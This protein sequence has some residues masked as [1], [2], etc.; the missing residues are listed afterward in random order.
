MAVHEPRKGRVVR[1]LLGRQ[2]AKRDVLFARAL[3]HARG[4]DPTRIGVEQQRNHYRRVIGRPATPIDAI[5]AIE[6][7]EVHLRDRVDDKP[8]QVPR[9][10]P[11]ADIRR[12]QK[13]LLTITRDKALSRAAIVLT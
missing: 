10:Q 4:P 3:D 2:H 8:R 13:R 12:H 7:I 1:A 11:L 5:G 6:R 9:R